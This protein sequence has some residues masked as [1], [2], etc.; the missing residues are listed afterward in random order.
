M[1]DLDSSL[2]LMRFLAVPW[3]L[4]PTLG[5]PLVVYLVARWRAYRDHD[6]D[7]ELG[8]KVALSYFAFIALQVLLLGT[9]TFLYAMLSTSEHN[10]DTYRVALGM[11]VP[12]CIVLGVHLAVLAR[13]TN[14]ARFP[15]VRRIFTGANLVLTGILGFTALVLASEALFNRHGMRDAGRIGG[16]GVIVYGSAWAVLAVQLARLTGRP[17]PPAAVSSPMTAVPG[18][19]GTAVPEPGLPPLGKGAFPPIE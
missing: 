19:A 15:A 2:W 17:A 13:R 4:F 6:V 12:A 14:Q 3:L 11:M 5:I 9:T 8:L 1:D 18:S 10:G 16:S 7:P